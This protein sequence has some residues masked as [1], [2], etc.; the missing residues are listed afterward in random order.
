M[1]SAQGMHIDIPPDAA[2]FYFAGR[3]L[4]NAKTLAQSVGRHEKTR[5]VV[6]IVQQGDG[7]PPKEV[8][9]IS[10]LPVAVSGKFLSEYSV[11][12]SGLCS[13]A[14]GRRHKRCSAV[15]SILQ[16]SFLQRRRLSCNL[17]DFWCFSLQKMDD[18]EYA[19]MLSYYYKKQEEQKVGAEFK[20][21]SGRVL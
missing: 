17:V 20:S 11:Q 9:W 18:K 10:T 16:F 5:A 7:A 14:M 21:A 15:F 6:W 8:R 4:D 3:L 12:W 1:I 2:I 19:K 13:R